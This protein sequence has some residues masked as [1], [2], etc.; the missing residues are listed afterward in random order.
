[1]SR[2][3]KAQLKYHLVSKD[4]VLPCLCAGVLV[5]ARYIFLP[6]LWTNVR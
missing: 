6:R 4:G 2:E 3:K 1:M 5:E